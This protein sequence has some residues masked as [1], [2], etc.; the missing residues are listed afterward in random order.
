[1]NL[2]ALDVVN[3]EQ[4]GKRGFV[5][6][7]YGEPRYF[8]EANISAASLRARMP[9]AHI[10][11]YVY[12]TQR[13]MIDSA[14]FDLI[15]T[16][17]PPAGD[18][19]KP[20]SKLFYAKINAIRFNSYREF[21]YLDTDTFVCEDL[22]PIFNL[23]NR[24]EVL[25]AHAPVR[26]RFRYENYNEPDFISDVPDPFCE[27]NTGVLGFRRNSTVEKFLK[28]WEEAYTALP[29]SGDQYL[30]MH[31]LYKSKASVYALPPEFN[32]RSIMPQYA[33]GKV[34]IVHGRHD[35][36]AS[37]ARILNESSEG[38]LSL[39]LA[40]EVSIITKSV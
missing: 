27:F 25:A 19:L 8:E 14:P 29:K 38:R 23:F 20:L 21:I 24:F 12:A 6:A 5:Y 35:N 13:D 39:P 26:R 22:T 30:F 9:G 2:Q 34:H 18:A 3:K 15:V 17:P 36:I 4:L 37:V 1:M 10:S 40:G 16:L 31:C 28:T 7:I 32:Y 11:A 33:F